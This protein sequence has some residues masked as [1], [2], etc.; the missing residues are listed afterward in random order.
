MSGGASI[1]HGRGL[2]G[3]YVKETRLTFDWWI[4]LSGLE[5]GQKM[6]ELI[7][8]QLCVWIADVLVPDAIFQSHSLFSVPRPSDAKIPPEA[9]SWQDLAQLS[10][11]VVR[12]EPLSLFWDPWS[13]KWPHLNTIAWPLP[14][15]GTEFR[16]SCVL[17][18][19]LLLSSILAPLQSFHC[20]Y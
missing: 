8:C 1:T 9:C 3:S 12:K 20:C 7:E 11:A 18:S 2:L 15:L 16:T 14:M 6:T 17:G 5:V 4:F 13:L 19:I 10:S